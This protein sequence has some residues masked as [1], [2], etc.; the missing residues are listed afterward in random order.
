MCRTGRPRLL[1]FLKNVVQ[2]SQC[3]FLSGDVHYGFAASGVFVE[4]K[5]ANELAFLQLTGSSLKNQDYQTLIHE[6]VGATVRNTPYPARPVFQWA[7]DTAFNTELL[8]LPLLQMG[9]G[10]ET[11][12][13]APDSNRMR[14]IL[15]ELA[16]ILQRLR[17]L[18]GDDPERPDLQ[19]RQTVLLDELRRIKSLLQDRPV[20]LTDVQAEPLAIQQEPSWQLFYRYIPFSPANQMAVGFNNIG[21]VRLELPELIVHTLVSPRDGGFRILE[22]QL[23]GIPQVEDH[24]RSIIP[25]GA[26]R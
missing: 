9:W 3:I 8:D 17:T 21:I 14:A 12:D 26:I 24:S 11:T 7:L 16:A 20:V 13:P 23:P 18:S 25:K 1:R 10:W 6:Y 2:P 5:V 15:D 19:T 22:Q 4:A